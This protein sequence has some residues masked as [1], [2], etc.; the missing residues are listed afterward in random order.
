MG[1]P[2]QELKA[3]LKHV[4]SCIHVMRMSQ[5]DFACFWYSTLKL[6]LSSREIV[7][8][9]VTHSKEPA[10]LCRLTTTLHA[11]SRRTSSNHQPSDLHATTC[12]K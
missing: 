4:S 6:E 2:T 7:K 8:Q 3:A 1:Q 10:P 12:R 5:M 9:T 11:C